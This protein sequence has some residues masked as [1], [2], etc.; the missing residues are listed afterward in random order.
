MFA[1]RTKPGPLGQA[2]GTY[3]TS[4]EEV[5]EIAMHAWQK[6]YAGNVADMASMVDNF[7]SKYGKAIF[8]SETFQ[9]GDITGQQVQEA[10][11][12]TKKSAA[13]MDKWEP[14]E[15]G[16]LSPILFNWIAV[17][18]NCIEQGAP[19]PDGTNHARAAYLSNC[20]LYTSD[21]ADE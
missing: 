19:W 11:V 4:P 14:A 13:G 7:I 8:T 15:L 3:A 17:M 6:V 21:A 16:L 20:L 10:C 12:H 9:I 2:I 5:D 1:K 18:L